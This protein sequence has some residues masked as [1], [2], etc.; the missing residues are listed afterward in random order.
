MGWDWYYSSSETTA[1]PTATAPL[2]T[3]VAAPTAIDPAVTPTLT[4]VPAT[5]AAV[6]ATVTTAHPPQV[7]N[8]IALAAR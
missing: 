2:A 1:L 4:A 8:T 6:V 7:P 3:V 5:E